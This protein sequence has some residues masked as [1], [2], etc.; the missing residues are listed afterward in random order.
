MTRGT[1]ADCRVEQVGADMEVLGIHADSV[2][3]IVLDPNRQIQA[4][5]EIDQHAKALIDSHAVIPL[6]L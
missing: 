1:V 4:V 5:A 6:S 3:R 2:W